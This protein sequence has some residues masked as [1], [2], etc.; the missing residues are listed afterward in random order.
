[1]VTVGGDGTF[2]E[3][4]SGFMS[5]KDDSYSSIPLGL[6]PAGT[7]NS[8]AN[9]ME[10]TDSGSHLG[11][12]KLPPHPPPPPVERRLADSGSFTASG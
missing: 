6:V 7:G 12:R 5:R 1:M 8:Q 9:D 2:C 4:I 11:I 10:I 3:V